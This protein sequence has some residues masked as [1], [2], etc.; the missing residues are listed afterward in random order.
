MAQRPLE[1]VRLLDFTWIL[2]GPQNAE[3]LISMGAEAIK[4]E[5]NVFPDLVRR[6]PR[7]VADDR[8]GLN[9]SGTFNAINRGNRSIT[10]NLEKPQALELVKDLV[11]KW[12]PDIVTENFV[13]GAMTRRG[14]AYEDIRKIKP[15]IIYCSMS[16]LGNTGPYAWH[17][18]WGPTVQARTGMSALSGYREDQF[19]RSL[20]GTFPDYPMAGIVAFAILMA[21][22]HRNRT[23]EGQYL[24]FAQNEGVIQMLGDAMMDY[25]INGRVQTM[26]GSRDP[27]WAPQGVYPCAGQ[28]N[29]VGISVANDA[30]FVA[31]CQ[32]MGRPELAQ[33][34]RFADALS[35]QR[36]H[37]ELDALIAEWTKQ[38]TNYEVMETLQ[39]MGVAAGAAVDTEQFVQ[40]PHLWARGFFLE[41][42]HDEV[43]RRL[44]GGWPVHLSEVEPQVGKAPLLGQHNQE[45]FR[46]ILGLSEEEIQRLVEEQVIC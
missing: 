8:P 22:W 11:R 6:G 17:R 46:G 36:H 27:L 43:G 12:Q 20:G 44:Y 38:H 41:V 32:A 3:Y 10:L 14:L 26:R 21:L 18:G 28:D 34:P 30:Q 39:G 7:P 19:P 5:S 29:W 23:G 16:L 40:D 15:D 33:D 1:G 25:T 13:V 24:D 2:I 31:L 42:D 37:D 9:R 35:R 45:V 4:I